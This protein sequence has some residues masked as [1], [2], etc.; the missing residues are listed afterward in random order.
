M[1]NITDTGK[2][3]MSFKEG[4]AETDVSRRILQWHF[5][6]MSFDIAGFWKKTV[7]HT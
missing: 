1:Q 4:A 5:S 6:S 2:D 3:K 7:H